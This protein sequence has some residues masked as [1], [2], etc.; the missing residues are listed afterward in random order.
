MQGQLREPL[1]TKLAKKYKNTGILNTRATPGNLQLAMY[2]CCV[3]YAPPLLIDVVLFFAASPPSVLHLVVHPAQ[4]ALEGHPEEPGL[5][6]GRSRGRLLLLPRLCLQPQPL[7]V[8][9]VTLRVRL[10]QPPG[11]GAV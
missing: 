6:N 2:K 1:L 5:D 8:V 11:R 9:R 4:A 7:R 3:N 10:R